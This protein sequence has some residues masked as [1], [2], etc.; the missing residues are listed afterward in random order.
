MRYYFTTGA[1]SI[2]NSGR[3]ALFLVLEGDIVAALFVVCE[4]LMGISDESGRSMVDFF[5]I[6]YAQYRVFFVK[7]H[8]AKNLGKDK[9]FYFRW[10]SIFPFNIN[11]IWSWVTNNIVII[12]TWGSCS[13]KDLSTGTNGAIIWP[14]V[15]NND[16]YTI[17]LLAKIVL[18]EGTKK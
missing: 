6:I 7:L 9:L 17:L 15:A 16:T 3:C 1:L 8:T 18:K 10:I 2:R 4:D 12:W 5:A 14:I 11:F 13:Y